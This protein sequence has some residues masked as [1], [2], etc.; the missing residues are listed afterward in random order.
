MVEIE[1]LAA[2]ADIDPEFYER[3]YHLGPRDGGDGAYRPLHEALTRTGRAAIGRFTF[4]E[5]A[6]L[7]AI[8]PLGAVLVLHT[9]RFADEVVP[10]QESGLEAPERAPPSASWRSPA[11]SSGA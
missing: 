9:M 6:Y 5:R 1:A 4:Y 2:A 3:P 7:V 8:R 11:G 10:W